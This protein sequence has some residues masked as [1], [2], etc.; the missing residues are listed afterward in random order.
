VN[1]RNVIL[2]LHLSAMVLMAAPYYNLV[3]VGERGRFGKAHVDVDR[4]FERL[5][6]GILFRCYFVQWAVLV[7]GGLLLLSRGLPL[8]TAVTNGPLLVKLLAWSAIMAIHNIVY[9]V[10]QPRIDSLLAGVEAESVPPEMAPPLA[11]LRLA[12]K[13]G[14]ACCLFLVLL[15]VVFGPQV[16]ASFSREVILFLVGIALLFTWS[17]YRTGARYGLI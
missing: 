16:W 5:V 2:V 6:K 7:L 12:R 10:I 14:A 13:R 17:V 15:A 9:F 8:S 3:I 11:S 1:T 4:Y